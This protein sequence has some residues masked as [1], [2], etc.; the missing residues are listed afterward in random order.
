MKQDLIE[1]HSTTQSVILHLLPGILVA[2]LLF[3]RQPV[4]KMG[5]PSIFALYLAFAFVLVPVN[6]DSCY[7]KEERRDILHYRASSAI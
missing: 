3:A 1:K 5:Y 4:A 7:I 2:F 6:L